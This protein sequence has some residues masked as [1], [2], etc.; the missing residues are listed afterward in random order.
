MLAGEQRGWYDDCDLHA[1][2]GGHE[3]GTEGHFGFSEADVAADEAVHRAAGGEIGEHGFDAER[4]IFGFLVG[5]AGDEFV[6]GAGGRRNGRG[7]FEL[8]EGRDLDQFA[9][10]FAQAVLEAGFARL[11]RAAAE[12][13]ELAVAFV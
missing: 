3:R 12:P 5:E 11:P 9:G 7:F 8:A 2:E 10:D 4:L 6:P 1:V 13:I